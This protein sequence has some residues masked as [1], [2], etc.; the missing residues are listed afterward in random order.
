MSLKTIE[1]Q[2]AIPRTQDASKIQ[3]E[4]N[5]RSN[6]ANAQASIA[7]VKEDEKRCKTVIKNGATSKLQTN[8]DDKYNKEKDE[9]SLPKKSRR[10]EGEPSTNHPFK[11]HIIDIRG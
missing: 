1:L 8:L 5:E 4:L 10:D 9:Q 2:I 7:V 3:N 11:G 6:H